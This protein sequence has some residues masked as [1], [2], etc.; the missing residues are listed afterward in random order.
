MKYAFMSFSTPDLTL[1][2]MLA[3]AGRLGYAGIEPRLAEGHKHGIETGISAAQRRQVR[4]KVAASG[5]R[6]TRERALS[7]TPLPSGKRSTS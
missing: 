5:I 3:L 1:D 2:E 4:E 7:F 6:P